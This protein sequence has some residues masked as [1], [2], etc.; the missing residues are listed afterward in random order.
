MQA[1]LRSHLTYA[2]VISTLCLFL[3]LGGGT[4]VALNGS[5]TVF[6]DDIVNGQVQQVDLKPAEPFR[7]VGAAGQPAFAQWGQVGG[8]C[9]GDCRWTNYDSTHN[10]AGFYRDPYGRVHLKGLVCGKVPGQT[11]CV[12]GSDPVT[13]P[14]LVDDIFTLPLGYRPAKTMEFATSSAGQFARL[15]V[16]PNGTVNAAG[17]FDYNHIYLDSVNFRC[18]PSGQNGCP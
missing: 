11:F 16:K 6:S 17:P 13:D 12:Q 14:Q 7:Q 18:V 9:S 8:H 10:S 4:A 1:W 3:L 2:N 5:N 15:I